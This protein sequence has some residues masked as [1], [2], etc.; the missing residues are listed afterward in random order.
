[1]TAGEVEATIEDSM[2]TNNNSIEE[3]VDTDVNVG[4]GDVEGTQSTH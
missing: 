3:S 4:N 1:M 2:D